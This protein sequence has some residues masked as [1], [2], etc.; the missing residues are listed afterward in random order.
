[1]GADVYILVYVDDLLIISDK[2]EAAELVQKTVTTAFKA[3]VMG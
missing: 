1:M 2:A 3:R